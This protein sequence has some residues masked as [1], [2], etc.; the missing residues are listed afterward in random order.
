MGEM[1]ISF[2]ASALTPPAVAGDCGFT[3]YYND[4]GSDDW[5]GSGSFWFDCGG[6]ATMED[7]I[8]AILELF[9]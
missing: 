6:G 5:G 4:G 7:I 3:V 9:F 8:N 1:L 2:P